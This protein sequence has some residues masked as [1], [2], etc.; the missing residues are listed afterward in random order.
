MKGLRPSSQASES[1]EA[2]PSSP[3]FRERKA[4]NRIL[5]NDPGALRSFMDYW[6]DIRYPNTIR[7][8]SYNTELKV[9]MS[10]SAPQASLLGGPAHP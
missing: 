6:T 5:F 8:K 4:P 9:K 2:S 1:W 10:V 3:L 7:E